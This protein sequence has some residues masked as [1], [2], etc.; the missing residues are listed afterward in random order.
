MDYE[1]HLAH[2]PAGQPLRVNLLV[3]PG[4]SLMTYASAVDPLRV[5]NRVAARTVFDWRLISTDGNAPLSSAGLALPVG[6]AFRPDQPCEVFAVI[7]GFRAREMQDRDLSR[8]VFRAARAAPLT[9]GIEAGA[10][11]LARAGLLDGRRATTHWEDLEDFAAAFPLVD[12]RSERFVADGAMLTTS[13]AAPTFEMMIDLIRLRAGQAVALDVAGVF[14]H[15]IAG[16][17]GDP[18]SPVAFGTS[19]RFDPR[20]VRAVGIMQGHLDDPLP[21]AAIAARCGLTSRG[22]ELL[23]RRQIGRTPGRYFLSLRLGAARKMLRDTVAPVG[24]IAGR[25]G[26]SSAAAFSRAYRGEFGLSPKSDRTSR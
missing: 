3:L 23:F 21:V 18:Q 16:R 8:G 26:F 22:L 2:L 15:E 13:G 7:A 24:E 11:V 6:G 17:P 10:W 25:A 14:N 9:L 1:I 4:S 12:L 20:L 19:G 5:A